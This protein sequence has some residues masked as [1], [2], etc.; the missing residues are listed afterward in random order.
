MP[1]TLAH[2]GLQGVLTRK[3]IDN[4]DLK[5]VY[6]GCIIPD[7]PW[8]LQRV[9]ISLIPG[10]NLYSLR[11]YV[12]IQSSLLFC[13]VLSAGIATHSNDFWKTFKILGINSFFH[14]FLDAFQTK[15]ANGVQFF[16]PFNWSLANLGLFW[17]ESIPTY[18]LT[19]FGLTYFFINWKRCTSTHTTLVVKST[20]RISQTALI[21]MVYIFTPLLLLNFPVS[22]NN[23]FMKTL[24][25]DHDR[26]G[27]YIE[28]DRR[29]FKP[30][31][32]GDMLNTF[33]NERIG[34]NGIEYNKN[35]TVSVRGTFISNE[36]IDV[37]EYHV[38]ST[39]FRNYASYL[40]LMLITLL[41]IWEP[42]Y[43][44]I[45]ILTQKVKHNKEKQ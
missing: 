31:P 7:F 18:T 9:L 37:I 13:L 15:F 21:L 3:L 29:G 30:N 27:E 24:R 25:P 5:W 28:F 39:W 43:I 17:P 41:W 45:R 10:L 12:I 2:I 33:A 11:S 34:I 20:F 8:I 44:K 1:N 22:S 14:L 36:M 4:T 42:A 35:A 26:T 40:G 16:V 38:H 6:V 19:I 23:H 32:N